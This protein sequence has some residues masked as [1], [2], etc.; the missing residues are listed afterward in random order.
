MERGC[1][2]GDRDD[3]G[4]PVAIDVAGARP[5]LELAR[6]EGSELRGSEDELGGRARRQ[7]EAQAARR[8]D[9]SDDAHAHS[10]GDDRSVTAI[11]GCEQ[12]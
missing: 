5:H 6:R 4:E 3:I 1:T 2:T 10:S 7:H 12:G 8:Q 11:S 9:G